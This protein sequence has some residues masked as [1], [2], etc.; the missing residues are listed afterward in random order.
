MENSIT[1][2][3]KMK[4]TTVFIQRGIDHVVIVRVVWEGAMSATFDFLRIARVLKISA[5]LI[6]QQIERA[7]TKQTIE[8]FGIAIL[9]ARKILARGVSEKFVAV[10]HANFPY[11]VSG[12]AHCRF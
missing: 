3:G 4:I 11:L 8:A 7:I 12:K 5:A 9:M 10:V 1:T 2:G 6:S